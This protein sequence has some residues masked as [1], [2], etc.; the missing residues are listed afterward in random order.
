MRMPDGYGPAG[1]LVFKL[2]RSIYEIRKAPRA[3]NKR[4]TQDLRF[5]GY[6]PLINSERVFRSTV[7]GV[8]VYLIIYVDDILF[9]TESMK[10]M[11]SVKK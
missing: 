2:N 8:V 4:L 5:A 10:V 9:L 11:L 6:N 7:H 1:G 3:W